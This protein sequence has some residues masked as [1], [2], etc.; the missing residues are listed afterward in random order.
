MKKTVAYIIY[1][2]AATM[3]FLYYLFPSDALENYMAYHVSRLWPPLQIETGQMSPSLPPGLKVDNPVIYRERQAIAG[4]DWIK[5]MPA[6]VSLFSNQKEVRFR[7]GAYQGGFTGTA[8]FSES[9]ASSV[10]DLELVFGGIQI[11]QIPG[12]SALVPHGVTGDV[13]GKVHLG[14][15]GSPSGQGSMEMTIIDGLLSLNPPVLEIRELSFKS[16]ELTADLA[17]GRI[18]IT[19]FDVNG[20]QVNINASGTIVLREP[21]DASAVNISGKI[22]P[23]PSFIR[24]LSGVVPPGLISERTISSGGIPFRI[25]GTMANPGFSLR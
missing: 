11:G 5:L 24:N 18:R 7:G 19:R 16:I 15:I 13:S 25:S 23:H 2:L 22:L 8:A 1:T 3:I 9:G 20:Q 12:I 6:W 21:L 17:D 10:S 4:A 14:N